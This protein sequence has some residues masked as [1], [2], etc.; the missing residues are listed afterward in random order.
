ML[1]KYSVE[2]LSPVESSQGFDAFFNA[3][4]PRNYDD[5]TKTCLS[6]M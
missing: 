6:L 1:H 3:Q 4:I 5:I 2:K